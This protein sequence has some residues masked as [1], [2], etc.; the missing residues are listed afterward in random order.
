MLDKYIRI[1]GHS[2]EMVFPFGDKGAWREFADE[3]V[4]NGFTILEKSN[5][6]TAGY[7]IAHS[8]SKLAI[9]EAKK[10]K[11]KL[12][13]R[14]LVIW[15]PKV[16]DEKIRKPSV[17]K[18]YGNVFVPS[19][20]WNVESSLTRFKWPQSVTNFV[21]PTFTEWLDREN[22]PVIIQANKF[23]VHKDE[24]YSLRRQVINKLEKSEYPVA[25]YGS[26]WNK[27]I[28]FNV[29]S[30][31]GSTRNVYLRNWRLSTLKSQVNNY[32]GYRGVAVDKQQVN[33]RYRC[34]IV[35]ENSLDYVS[36]KLFDAVSS[37]TYVIYVGP[38]LS[39][40]GL[41]SFH[42]EQLEPSASVITQAVD[43]FLSLNPEVQFHL[44][45]TQRE[46]LKKYLDSFNN[47]NVLTN[48]ARTCVA[49]FI[50]E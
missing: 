23:S 18:N 30:W 29:R 16:I 22:V 4:K 14:I 1:V 13:H 2:K 5:V 44:M 50:G 46:S 17:L 28:L 11:T 6:S 40:F 10:N 21:I 48:L 15:E 41:G 47:S 49:K 25:L 45:N 26:N 20:Y 43:K 3:I 34:T 39:D 7:L 8:H 24:K 38:N 12:N 31:L 9:R 37:G 19:E 35:I 36:E 27:G 32:A 33:A 42:L